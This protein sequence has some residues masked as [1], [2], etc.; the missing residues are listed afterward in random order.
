MLFNFLGGLASLI[1][2]YIGVSISND[3]QAGEWILVITA[4]M[5]IYIG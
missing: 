3:F 5:F 4:G 2:F 1:G